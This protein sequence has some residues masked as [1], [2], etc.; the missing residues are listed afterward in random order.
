MT[1]RKPGQV[2]KNLVDEKQ[3]AGYKS[4]GWNSSSV[5]SGVYFYRLEAT[6]TNNPQQSYM[7]VK[8]MVVLK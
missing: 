5:A 4:V 7:N 3:T 2:V 8:R 6:N 1:K